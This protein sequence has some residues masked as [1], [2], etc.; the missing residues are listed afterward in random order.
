MSDDEATVDHY[1]ALQISAN[2]ELDTIHRVYR[3]LAQR[4]HPDNSETGDASR[5]RSISEAYRVLS[6]PESRA[7]YDVLHAARQQRRWRL[8]TTGKPV[9]TRLR[10]RARFFA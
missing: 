1:E 3:L 6:E 8:V 10:V 4:F 5:F 2:A 7:Q 9:G